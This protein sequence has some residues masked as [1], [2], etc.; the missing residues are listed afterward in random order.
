MKLLSIA[1]T[2]LGIWVFLNAI[3]GPNAMWNGIIFGAITALLPLKLSSGYL[4]LSSVFTLI[5][6][7]IL[8]ENPNLW[9][10]CCLSPIKIYYNDYR[11]YKIIYYVVN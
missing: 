3:L 10:Y 8:T 1:I 7:L 4:K 2:S 11:R 5:A 6:H 9:R